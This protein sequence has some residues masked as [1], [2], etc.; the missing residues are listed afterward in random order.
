[1]ETFFYRCVIKSI[2]LFVADEED[3]FMVSDL[4]LGGDLRYHLN[5]EV[6]FSEDCVKFYVCELSLALD[7]LQKKHI[8]HR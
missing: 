6:H 2:V 1:M 5:N 3:L 4:L 8:V 7:Y